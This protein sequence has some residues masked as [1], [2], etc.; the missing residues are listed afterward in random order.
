VFLKGLAADMNTPHLETLA[1]NAPI[2]WTYRGQ[3]MPDKKEVTTVIEL[4]RIEAEAD[5]FFIEASGSLWCDELRVYEVN[6][7]SVR[8]RDLD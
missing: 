6:T 4:T 3:V 2:A 8:L 7:M 5:G 1:T